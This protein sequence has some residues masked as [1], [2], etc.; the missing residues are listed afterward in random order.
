MRVQAARGRGVVR[1][2]APPAPPTVRRD[3]TYLLRTEARSRPVHGFVFVDEDGDYKSFDPRKALHVAAWLRHAAHVE[4]KRLRLDP[5]FIEQFVCGHGVSVSEKENRFS[6]LPLPTISGFRDGR[7]RRALLVEPVGAPS[8]QALK[9]I[10][11]LGNSSLIDEEG[12]VKAELRGADPGREDGVFQQYL[13]P[14]R[15]WGSVTP[16]VL[17]GLD[18]KRSRKAIGLVTKA[19]AQAGHTTR[20]AEISVQAEPVFP[21]AEMAGGYILPQHLKR[22]PCVH[23]I[24]SFAEP[25]IGPVVVGGGRHSGLGVFAA[26]D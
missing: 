3:V 5:Q 16:V 1:S 24:L 20:V 26:L 15:T 23:V 14:S 21:G 22:W 25:S 8:A 4:A 18:D 9:V 19:L 17:P 11:A 13:R 2:V 12:E 10:R 6:Y 7:I